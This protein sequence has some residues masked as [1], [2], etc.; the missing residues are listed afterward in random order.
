MNK[1]NVKIKV[2]NKIGMTTSIIPHRNGFYPIW[3][4][5]SDTVKFIEVSKVE[6]IRTI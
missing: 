5:N 3:F 6:F 2:G 4:K 1:V